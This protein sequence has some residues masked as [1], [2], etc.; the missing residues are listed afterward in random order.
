MAVG[1]VF[2]IFMKTTD[3]TRQPS[4]GVFEEVSAIGKNGGTNP[5]QMWDGTNSIDIINSANVTGRDIVDS[6]QAGAQTYN[7]AI[8]IG[9]TVYIRKSGSGD[10]M[11]VSGV[12]VDA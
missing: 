2:A 10:V 1:D 6:I 3:V 11:G 8:K 7:M 4:A 5:I 12:Q 9:N